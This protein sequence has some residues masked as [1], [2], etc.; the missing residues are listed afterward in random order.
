MNLGQNMDVSL[1]LQGST[2][3]DQ[4]STMLRSTLQ[5]STDQDQGSTDLDLGSTVRGQAVTHLALD[6]TTQFWGVS[7]QKQMSPPE[8]DQVRYAFLPAVTVST[9]STIT[10]G[11]DMNTYPC[12]DNAHLNHSA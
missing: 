9:C 12:H 8:E 10:V 11:S 4:G 2:M 7:S 6:T 5:G 3:L 1:L